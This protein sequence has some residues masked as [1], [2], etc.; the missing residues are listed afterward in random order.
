MSLKNDA[1]ALTDKAS[2]AFKNLRT[3]EKRRKTAKTAFGPWAHYMAIGTA[4]V[5]FCM[6]LEGLWWDYTWKHFPQSD[7]H[8]PWPGRCGLYCIALSVV[9][10]P[11]EICFGK[12]RTRFP[13]PI[14]GAFYIATSLFLFKSKVTFL[15]GVFYFWIGLANVVS[16]LLKEE[17]DPPQKGPPAPKAKRPEE[18]CLDAM[19]KWAV[20]VLEHNEVGKVMF[21]IVYFAANIFLFFFILNRWIGLNNAFDPYTQRLSQWGP[22]AKAFGNLLDFNCSLLLLPVLRTVHRWMFNRA[23]RDSGCVALFF[24]KLLHYIPLDHALSFH[25]LIAAM[26]MMASLAHGFG[27]FINFAVA[28]F[29]TLTLFGTWPWLSGGAICFAM[30]NIYSTIWE[31]VKMAQFE[32]FWYNHHWFIVFYA[33]ILSHGMDGW[34]KNFWPWF[35]VPACLYA[36]ERYMRYWRASQPIILLSCTMMDG[37]VSIELAKSGPLADYKEGQYCFVMSPVISRLQWHPFTISSAPEQKSVTFHMKCCGP[38]S[39]TQSLKDYL[40]AL[41]PNGK[42]QAWLAFTRQ[43]REP[44][45][46]LGPKR[47]GLVYG[48]DGRQLICIDGPHAAPTQHIGEY[49]TAVVVGAG[50]GVTPVAA[51]L[52]AVLF[53]RWKYSLGRTYPQSAYFVWVCSHRDLFSFRWFVRA[54][55]DAQDEILHMRQTDPKNMSNKHFHVWAYITSVPKDVK[56][57]TVP[58]ASDVSF[59]GQPRAESKMLKAHAPFSEADLYRA[60]DNPQAQVQEFGDI[61]VTEGRPKWSVPFTQIRNTHPGEVGVMFCGNPMI[62]SDLG[63]ACYYASRGRPC[64]VFKFHKENF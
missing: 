51:T 9:V 53:H 36:T 50:I 49:Q 23:T 8:G 14:R 56:P 3:V 55:K 62:A 43:E 35:V 2:Q 25:K 33:G 47:R 1:K 37:V 32:I 11:I 38:G 44:D 27:H 22:F 17:Y 16:A 39:W 12:K 34:Q 63:D 6:G 57:V 61:T 31:E 30:L 60:M 20:Q 4:V 64:G 28:P 21:L 42:S 5:G 26:V 52:K 59:W 45:G 7:R 24:R 41:V 19:F 54:I 40:I 18:G 46:T 48:P 29:Q 13:F 15:I 58:D 10:L